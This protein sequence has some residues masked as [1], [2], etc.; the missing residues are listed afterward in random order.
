MWWVVFG[1]PLI[2]AGAL[3][4]QILIVMRGD[5]L[6]PPG[7]TVSAEVGSPTGDHEEPL[8]VAVIGDSTVAGTGADDIDGTLPVLLGERLAV[9]LGRRVS[10]VGHGISGARTGDLIGTQVPRIDGADVVLVVIGSNDV[11]HLTPPWVLRK[12]TRQLLESLRET[13]VVLGGVPLFGGATALPQ[14]LRWLVGRYAAVLREVQRDVAVP[15]EGVEFVDIAREASPRFRG[16]PDA[17]SGDGFH[18]SAVGYGF[19]ADAL[20]AGVVR[21][22]DRSAAG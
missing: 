1:A 11:T 17:M 12:Q 9:A 2:A 21:A 13:P 5:Y 6:A 4:V 3:A 20:A 18:P 14:P 16:V 22:V 10:V 19:W 15:A 7:G 8:R